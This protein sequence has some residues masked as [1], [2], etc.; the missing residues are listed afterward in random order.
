MGD[1]GAPQAADSLEAER[2]RVKGELPGWDAWYQ[3]IH[4]PRGI[5]WCGKPA[6]HPIA[7]A[8]G[9]SGDE[10]IENA[11]AWIARQEAAALLQ[12][13]FGHWFTVTA[14]FPFFDA[15]PVNGANVHFE[16]S[17]PDGMRRQLDA[18]TGP[19]AI[20]QYL[21]D[22]P[23]AEAWDGDGG[24][25]YTDSYAQ[26]G[27]VPRWQ[28][29]PGLRRLAAERQACARIE[30]GLPDGWAAWASPDG[31]WGVTPP[32]GPEITGPGEAGLREALAEAGV[33]A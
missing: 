22:H 30:A 25:R 18:V 14:R 26:R 3:R 7:V 24:W 19:E 20:A 21:K 29:I 10:L 12:Q 23:W 1:A 27:P 2:A 9:D 31:T 28:V 11:R 17:D 8:W 5:R 16:D 32:D 4:L 15:R 13:D 33:L 6:D